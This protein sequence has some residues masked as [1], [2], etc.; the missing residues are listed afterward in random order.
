MSGVVVSA[1]YPSITAVD[2]RLGHILFPY[3]RENTVMTAIVI[4]IKFSSAEFD[5]RWSPF[6]M[7]DEIL[8]GKTRNRALCIQV[9]LRSITVPNLW[10][11]SIINVMQ[12]PNFALSL[13]I[14]GGCVVTF[15]YTT[16]WRMPS[17]TGTW[18]DSANL[19]FAHG[20]M[21]RSLVA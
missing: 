10:R 19:R 18:L 3:N 7:E 16:K 14:H 1:I 17:N 12:F 8:I 13:R 21:K 9:G 11:S 20:L 5:S 2:K 4:R 15:R 6:W